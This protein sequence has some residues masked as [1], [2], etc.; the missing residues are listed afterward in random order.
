MHATVASPPWNTTA[1][2][3]V[4]CSF[5]CLCERPPAG[6][7]HTGRTAVPDVTGDPTPFL[8][9]ICIWGSGLWVWGSPSILSQPSLAGVY[10]TPLLSWLHQQA[11]YTY[12]SRSSR[13][14][15]PMHSLP[16]TH[17]PL[18]PPI[19][20]YTHIS[21]HAKP[22]G[23][24]TKLASAQPGCL[25]WPSQQ[26]LRTHIS[27]TSR[28]HPQTHPPPSTHAHTPIHPPQTHT[29]THLTQATTHT[30]PATSK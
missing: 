20:I 22:H 5:C 23:T 26:A 7:V 30:H 1:A 11:V 6:Q 16:P 18:C 4:P 28:K 21:K 9:W 17:L 19:H 15:P 25:I 27:R 24:P 3:G 10:P 12:T 8:A 2:A 13:E 14:H 29:H